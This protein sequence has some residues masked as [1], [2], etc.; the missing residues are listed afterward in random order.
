LVV[1]AP[2]GT[3][4]TTICRAV[5]Q[6]LPGVEFSVS[7]TTRA[8]RG[9]E[10]DG[11]DYHF[12]SE[13]A[14]EQLVDRGAFLEW[15]HVHKNR[16]GTAR[17][18]VEERLGRG[19]DVLFDIDVQGGRQIAERL[20]TAVLVFILPPSLAELEARLRGRGTETE[21]QIR[22]RLEATRA[23]IEAAYCYTHWI[24]NDDLDRAVDDLSAIL[25]AE[26]IRNT[27]VAELKRRVLGGAS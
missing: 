7:H 1:S 14:F 21:A 5:M 27:D 15:A 20:E 16:Y 13:A 18:P 23:E 26:R 4:K 19:I 25:V 3:G 9:R 10:Q 11:V 17:A 24:I 8:P 6:R 2:S 12:V 22:G